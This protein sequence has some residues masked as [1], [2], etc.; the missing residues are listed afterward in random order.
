MAWYEALAAG[1]VSGAALL[2]GAEL[3]ARHQRRLAKDPRQEDRKDRDTERRS[4]AYRQYFR[5]LAQIP[6]AKQDDSSGLASAQQGRVAVADLLLYG[7]PTV[8]AKA[9]DVEAAL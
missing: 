6:L 8:K 7:S 2:A 9:K 1:L 5:W 3:N 4:E